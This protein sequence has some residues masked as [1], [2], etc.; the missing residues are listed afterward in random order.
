MGL[1]TPP[2][3]IRQ[4]RNAKAFKGPSGGLSRQRVLRIKTPVSGSEHAALAALRSLSSDRCGFVAR[5]A[6]EVVGST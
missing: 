6:S 3:G 1:G 2:S 5:P 4:E